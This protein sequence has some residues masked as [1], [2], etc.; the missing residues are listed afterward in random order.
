MKSSLKHW[1]LLL[2]CVIPILVNQETGVKVTEVKA[3]DHHD[4]HDDLT[5]LAQGH[6]TTT[7]QSQAELMGAQP[8][9]SLGLLS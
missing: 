6:V 7:N 3:V 9:R 8:I 4:N 2:F 1:I 5:L